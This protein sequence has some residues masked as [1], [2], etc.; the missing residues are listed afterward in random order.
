MQ[1]NRPDQPGNTRRQWLASAWRWCAMTV[2]A[3]L[4]GRLV[5]RSGS[6]ADCGRHLPCRSCRLLA[7]CDLPRAGEA[8]R[9]KTRSQ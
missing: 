4:S 7:R 2:L 9:S 6:A 1:A 5:I 3:L 8:R